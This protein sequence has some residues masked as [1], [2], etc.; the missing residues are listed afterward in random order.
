[1]TNQ[2]L[3]ILTNGERIEKTSECWGCPFVSE[4]PLEEQRRII[5][6]E[7]K[8]VENVQV[9]GG[10]I[11]IGFTEDNQRMGSRVVSDTDLVVYLSM[12]GNMHI[13]Q[14]VVCYKSVESVADDVIGVVLDRMLDEVRFYLNG[15]LVAKSI[16]RP[17]S[18]KSVY[19][20]TNIFYWG[21]KLEICKKYLYSDLSNKI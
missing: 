5:Y 20:Y 3:Y 21:Q 19:A 13:R 17:S 11:V 14:D 4:K 15:K 7:I 1:M 16:R 6:F 9:Y 8:I 12:T 2:K 18:L 10:G